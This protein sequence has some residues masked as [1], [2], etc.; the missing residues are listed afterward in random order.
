MYCIQS[1][2][3]VM[4]KKTPAKGETSA[5]TGQINHSDAGPNRSTIPA[6]KIPNAIPKRKSTSKNGINAIPY[7]KNDNP[8]IVLARNSI[9]KSPTE[10]VPMLDKTSPLT[11]SEI[12]NGV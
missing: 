8:K 9:T 3:V 1:G 10:L 6:P 4:G 12:D 5:G 7:A 11:Y 2:S